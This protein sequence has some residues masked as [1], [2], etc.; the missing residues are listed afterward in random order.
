VAALWKGLPHQNDRAGNLFEKD[1]GTF[2]RCQDLYNL[3]KFAFIGS[4]SGEPWL[5][6]GI[7]AGIHGDEPAGSEALVALL[8]E[9]HDEPIL[10]SGMELHAYPVCNPSGFEDGTRWARGGP[11]LNREFWTQSSEPEVIL[12]ENELRGL[13]F[14]GLVSLHAD[15]TVNG[16]YG[17]VGGDVLTRNLLEPALA[18]ASEFLPRCT[19]CSIDGW[20]AKDAIIEDRFH[21]ILSA[22]SQQSPRPF[23]IIFETPALAPLEKQIAAHRAALL[24]I[25]DAAISLR[26]HAA[27]I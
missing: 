23:E 24:A 18:A 2:K 17:Y 4:A 27:N 14:D 3:R 15:D 20:T 12:L 26:S 5:R 16:V 25:F 6:L 1:L 22:P 9:L 13:R 8:S 21:G 19:D 7:F 10:A 11:D